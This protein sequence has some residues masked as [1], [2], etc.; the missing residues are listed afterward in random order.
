MRGDIEAGRSFAVFYLDEGRLVAAECVARP[1][2]FMM[3]KK[4]LALGA[5]PDPARLV[6]E[7]VPVKELMRELVQQAS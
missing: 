7:D 1:R 4:L 2:E 3:A 5:S 6:D